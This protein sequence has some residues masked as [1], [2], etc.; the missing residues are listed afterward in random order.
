[1]SL[2]GVLK[3]IQ[4]GNRLEGFEAIRQS[5][6]IDDVYAIDVYILWYYP[7]KVPFDLQDDGYSYI[8]IK[9]P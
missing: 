2:L 4:Q 7:I 9:K 8:K 1:V 3:H 6:L 5:Q